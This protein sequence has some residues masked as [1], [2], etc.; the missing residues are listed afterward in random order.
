MLIE[1]PFST[2]QLFGLL[3]AFA[4]IYIYISVCVCGF[5]KKQNDYFFFQNV[6]AKMYESKIWH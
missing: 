3:K 5:F 6:S 2:K 4:Y 1:K